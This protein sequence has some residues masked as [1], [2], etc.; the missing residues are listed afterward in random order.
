MRLAACCGVKT[1]ICFAWIVLNKSPIAVGVPWDTTTVVG[2]KMNPTRLVYIRFPAMDAQQPVQ[3]IPHVDQ[4]V[5]GL[6]VH[7]PNLEPCAPTPGFVTH[8]RVATWSV[9]KMP[10]GTVVGIAGLRCSVCLVCN[11]VCRC[12]LPACHPM[13]QVAMDVL[14]N[15]VFAPNIPRAVPTNGIC[16]APRHVS[17]SVATIVPHARKTR[18]ATRE[19]AAMS[20]EKIAEG[21]EP[22]KCVIKTNAASP[23][24]MEKNVARMGVV[25]NAAPAASNWNAPMANV[26]PASQNV[27]AKNVARMGAAAS[28][29]CV[30]SRCCVRVAPVSP[31]PVKV[32]VVPIT[33]RVAKDALALAPL[34]VR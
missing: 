23:I 26:S 5:R 15:P 8:R 24:V 6:V 3:W 7:V 13:G 17:W 34:S 4:N 25:A 1:M 29:G 21:V 11:G 10:K 31:V 32:D 27:Q 22:R 12:L 28:A 30:T 16:F 9:A 2:R 14:V 20:A 18:P 33:C 19:C